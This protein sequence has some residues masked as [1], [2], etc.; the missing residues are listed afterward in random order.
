MS[1]CAHDRLWPI[2]RLCKVW[3]VK[4]FL[5]SLHKWTWDLEA[6]KSRTFVKGVSPK[7]HTISNN[8]AHARYAFSMYCCILCNVYQSHIIC[9]YLG[10]WL[11][12]QLI[13]R[14][15]SGES[16]EETERAWHL[17]NQCAF[18]WDERRCDFC[19]KWRKPNR[20]AAQKKMKQ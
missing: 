8:K 11:T 16:E 4:S 7:D 5:V 3:A 19:Y 18:T 9:H 14:P 20:R 10:W 1:V 17:L 6:I 15:L 13:Q 2:S 12:N